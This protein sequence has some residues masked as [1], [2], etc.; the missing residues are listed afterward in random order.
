MP[1]EAHEHTH[2]K[3]ENKHTNKQTHTYL[4]NAGASECHNDSDYVDCELELQELGDAVVDVPP[5]HHR[6]HDAGEVVVCQDDVRG[7]L[8][9]VGASDALSSTQEGAVFRAG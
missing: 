1:I 8:C 2:N 7:L 5:P 6:L 3:Q 9:H 4:C